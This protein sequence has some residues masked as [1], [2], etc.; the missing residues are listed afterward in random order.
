M[1]KNKPVF[2]QNAEKCA[3]EVIKKVGKNIVLGTCT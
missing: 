2:Y 1:S 3:D